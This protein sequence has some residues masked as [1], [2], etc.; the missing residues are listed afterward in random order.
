MC[1]EVGGGMC[2][3]YIHFVECGFFHGDEHIEMSWTISL[4]FLHLNK[5][6]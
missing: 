4:H 1:R 3:H 6:E 5:G 2:M